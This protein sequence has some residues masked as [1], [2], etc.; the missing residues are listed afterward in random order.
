MRG[1]L[2]M[3]RNK[4]I[5]TIL[6]TIIVAAMAMILAG[7]GTG[8]YAVNEKDSE[9]EIT[10]P[11]RMRLFSGY[12]C[13]FSFL[14]PSEYRI[15][16]SENDGAYV[17]CGEENA[18]PYVLIYRENGKNMSPEKYFKSTDQLMLKSFENVESTPIQ[19]VRVLEKTLYLTRYQC[20]NGSKEYVIDRYFEP[21]PDF[22]LQY[23][24]IS[25][26]AG[27]LD[28]LLYY[29]IATSKL[30]E[31]AYAGAYSDKVSLHE[32]TDTG[33]SIKLPDMLKL[34][35]LTIGYFASNVNAIMVALLCTEDGG[36][37]IYNRQDFID[38]AAAN[39]NFVANFLGVDT[40]NFSEGEE[41]QFGGKSFYCYPMTMTSGE[42]TYTGSL[43][44]AN[45]DETGC[46]MLC[47]AV[48]DGCP[49][50]DDMMALC[51]S[52]IESISFK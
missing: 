12:D 43:C 10:V 16:W 33:M 9:T 48:L 32:H 35:D 22:Y 20:S 8:S 38:R 6:L 13:G 7:C 25:D 1:C 17:Y 49:A 39:P 47:Y 4:K 5:K 27:S 26:K 18:A 21:Y 44:I 30:A 15:G 52:C 45:A 51:A 42:E 28:T 2:K 31:E 14:Y 3:L 19:E 37:P 23:T 24:A 29:A 41:R 46:W 40:A 34:N 36:V 50:H 11:S